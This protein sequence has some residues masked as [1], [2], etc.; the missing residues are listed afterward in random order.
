MAPAT[1]VRGKEQRLIEMT[2]AA[3]ASISARLQD[4]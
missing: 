4:I 1:R 2:V 3:A